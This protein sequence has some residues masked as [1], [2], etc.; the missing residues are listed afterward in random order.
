MGDSH[1]L[2]LEQGVHLQGAQPDSQQLTR[3]LEEGLRRLNDTVSQGV[4]AYHAQLVALLQSLPQPTAGQPQEANAALLEFGRMLRER[5]QERLSL[6]NQEVQIL[7]LAASGLN[8]RDIGAR[9][10]WSEITIKRKMCDIYRKLGA[11]NRAQAVAE[12]V[13][14]GIV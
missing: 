4:L 14:M 3:I 1:H 7:E 10:F 9:Q 11:K 13:R 2:T 6:T 5:E 12:A 8:N